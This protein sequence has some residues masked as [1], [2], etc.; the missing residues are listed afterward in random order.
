MPSFNSLF[1]LNGKAELPNSPTPQ[2]SN[3]I[4][5]NPWIKALIAI[6]VILPL[7]AFSQCKFQD[8]LNEKI[9]NFIEGDL[10]KFRINEQALQSNSLE[11]QNHAYSLSIPCSCLPDSFIWEFSLELNLNT[12]SNNQFC[13]GFTFDDSTESYFQIGNSQDQLKFIQVGLDTFLGSPNDYNQSS[14]QSHIILA[15]KA[16]NLEISIFISETKRF[17]NHFITLPENQ[18]TN[19]FWRIS[20]NGKNAVG[21]HRISKLNL[22]AFKDIH[23]KLKINEIQ[24]LD[25]KTI[26]LNANQPL[27]IPDTVVLSINGIKPYLMD[28]Q[29]DLNTILIEYSSVNQDEIHFKTKGL[30]SYYGTTLDSQFT[31]KLNLP[32]EPIYGDLRISE[33]LFDALPSYGFLPETEFIEIENLQQKQLNLQ[34]LY[35]QINN[36]E[37]QVKGVLPDSI[38]FAIISPKCAEYPGVLCF[39]IPFNLMNSENT[40]VIKTL[41]GIPLDSLFLT[42]KMQDPLFAEGGVSLVNDKDE[43]P[44]PPIWSWHSHENKGGSPGQ[45][46]IPIQ[47][48]QFSKSFTKIQ[49]SIV[50]TSIHFTLLEGIKPDQWVYIKINNKLDSV[51]YLKGNEF[52]FKWHTLSDSCTLIFTNRFNR[53]NEITLPL[54]KHEFSNLQISEIHFE[55]PE[56]GDFVEL[57]NAGSKAVRMEDLDILIFDSDDKIKHIIPCSGSE[58]KW[59]FPNEY[60]AFTN[61]PYY[62]LREIDSTVPPN[63][64]SLN[65]FPNL[66]VSGGYIEIVHHLYGRID[67]APFNR[68]MHT[69]S[70]ANHKS[71]VKRS[72][73]LPSYYPSNW[74]SSLDLFRAASPSLGK[75]TNYNIHNQNTFS[76]E[77][78]KWLLNSN[79]NELKLTFNFKN[80]GYYVYVSLFDSHGKFI[81]SLL[82]GFQMPK[83]A[84]YPILLEDLPT[85]II[86]GNYVLKFEA[87]HINSQD[88]L[89]QLERISFIYE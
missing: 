50:N 38:K 29:Q 56:N 68:D 63:I 82:E 8:K 40:I 60:I 19:C 3:F 30:S 5:R 20:Q 61:N 51:Y 28:Y 31:V 4:K 21:S 13:F 44:F 24:F 47:R 42:T 14:S 70:N 89:R 45:A 81:K 64:I 57:Y 66:S 33:V 10:V 41:L 37:Y 17:I 79:E 83:K 25:A 32:K 34:S 53:S 69:H 43:G 27:R 22:T 54:I 35:L 67:K 72:P 18:I 55:A 52:S 85:L 77:R 65:M 46:G 23:A 36:K 39:E 78:R 12:S 7:N 9:P 59:F 11:T 62:W 48:A 80:E 73:Q 71:L 15:K 58:K 49:A 87:F 84:T 1:R 88:R 26:L 74:M 75:T 16:E 6:T 2:E 76:I 86:P